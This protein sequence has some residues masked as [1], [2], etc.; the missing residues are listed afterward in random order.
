MTL[1]LINR[2]LPIATNNM[3]MKFETENPK[4]TPET[5]LRTESRNWKIQYG[6]QAAILKMTSM[7]INWLLPIYTSIVLLNFGVYIQSQTKGA[8]TKKIQNGHQAAILEVTSL[9]IYWLLTINMC[10]KFEVEIPQ[11]TWLM[12]RKPCLQMDRWTDGRTNKVNLV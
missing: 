4:Q 5:M 10:M 11:Q 12:L 6:H 3:H 2:P 1:L 7:K 9:K 8:G